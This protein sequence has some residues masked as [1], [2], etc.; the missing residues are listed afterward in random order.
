MQKLNSAMIYRWGRALSPIRHQTT[1]TEPKVAMAALSIAMDAVQEIRHS[2]I[3]LRLSDVPAKDAYWAMK[4]LL[5]D[6]AK[7][8][9]GP[10]SASVEVVSKAVTA[11]RRLETL[12]EAELAIGDF[13]FVPK[14]GGYDT[15]ALLERGETLSPAS[16]EAKAPEAIADV[17]QAT[18]CLAFKLPTAAAFHLHRA[19]EAV[20]HRYF[21]AVSGGQPRPSRGPMGKY[22]DLLERC[23]RADKKVLGALRIVKDLHRNPVA[24]P[25]HTLESDEEANALLG[26]IVSVMHAMLCAIPD[27]VSTEPVPPPDDILGGAE[28]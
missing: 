27:A 10:T 22:I 9:D 16:L 14:L 2:S 19:N 28:G 4:V 5:D 20:L 18:R 21:D 25:E 11:V 6:I 23:D 3:G 8:Q 15:D 26:V 17:Q 13:Y 12:L 24:H 1:D 7:G